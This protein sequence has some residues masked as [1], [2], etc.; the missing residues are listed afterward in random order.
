MPGRIKR[1]DAAFS[2]SK[3][4]DG[5]WANRPL[6]RNGLPVAHMKIFERPN[7]TDGQRRQQT[8]LSLGS[9]PIMGYNPPNYPAS[10]TRARF[11]RGILADYPM[12]ARSTTVTTKET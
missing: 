11:K 8:I 1:A 7:E 10:G 9:S 4:V 5:G 6:L 12:V 2:A 3:H